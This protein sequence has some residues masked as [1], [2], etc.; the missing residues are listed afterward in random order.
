[1][2]LA[3]GYTNLYQGSS[4]TGV[5]IGGNPAV[6]GVYNG[7]LPNVEGASL[8]PGPSYIGG[9]K[10]EGP[11]FPTPH[12]GLVGVQLYNFPGRIIGPAIF[13]AQ[14]AGQ[15]LGHARPGQLDPG[16]RGPADH[17]RLDRRTPAC[18]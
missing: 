1:M 11:Q 7:Y 17:D 13:T 2:G 18:T 3:A 8:S 5:N 10:K 16:R 9:T 12:Q 14:R 15:L 6:G 4:A